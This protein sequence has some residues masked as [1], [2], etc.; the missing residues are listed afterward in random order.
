MRSET[1]VSLIQELRLR[2]WAR[3]NYVPAELRRD[4]EWHPLVLD[5]MRCRDAER[6]DELLAESP[7][8]HV[9]EI[10]RAAPKEEVVTRWD[11]QP[12][13]ATTLQ[14]QSGLRLDSATA[15]ERRLSRW[16]SRGSG[17]AGSRR[18]L[19]CSRTSLTTAAPR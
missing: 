9:N 5:E 4:D 13:I 14:Q 11:F 16:R 6:L 15:T 12:V 7:F 10:L 8:V 18:E 19:S 3:R 17:V 1:P 2:L